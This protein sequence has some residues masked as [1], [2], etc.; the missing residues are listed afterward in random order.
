M[1]DDIFIIGLN[2]ASQIAE[3]RTWIEDL[4]GVRLALQSDSSNDPDLCKCRVSYNGPDAQEILEK[5]K[6]CT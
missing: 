2:Q 6:V 3:N 4:F 5:T 1:E